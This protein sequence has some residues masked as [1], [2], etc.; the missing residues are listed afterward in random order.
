MGWDESNQL[1]GMG[2][3][4]PEHGDEKMR[5]CRLCGQDFCIGCFPGSAV[6]PGCAEEAEEDDFAV[7]EDA[8]LMKEVGELIGTDEI[9]EDVDDLD[10]LEVSDTL[11]DDEY[12]ERQDV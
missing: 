6:C 4:C 8:A 10:E 11:V 12:D 7:D 5:E 2:Q 9:D 1:F 3:E